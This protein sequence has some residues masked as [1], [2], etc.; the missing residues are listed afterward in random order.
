[1]KRKVL[2]I[3]GI[4]FVFSWD[5]L[6]FFLYKE[7]GLGYFNVF[8]R[9]ILFLSLRFYIVFC[10]KKKKE[11]KRRSL[12]KS[13]GLGCGRSWVWKAVVIGLFR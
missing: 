2:E 1:M 10:F 13:C 7:A 6:F 9:V 4:S 3:F 8:F 12:G 5:F 11:K